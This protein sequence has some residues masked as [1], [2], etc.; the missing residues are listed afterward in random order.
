MASVQIN[1]KWGFIDSTGQIVIHP[2]YYIRSNF[3][4]G[5]APVSIKVDVTDSKSYL[6]KAFIDK[7]R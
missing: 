5:L 1:R 4:E 6:I 3:S 2:K 7:L